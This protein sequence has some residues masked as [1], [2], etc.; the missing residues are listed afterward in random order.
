ML[1]E[2]SQFARQHW[3]IG[4]ILISLLWFFAGKQSLSNGRPD[5]AK[6]WQTIAV[7]IILIMCGWAVAERQWLGLALGITIFCMEARCIRD[8]YTEIRKN[9]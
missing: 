8:A 9:R 3:V 5:A 6:F 1:S 2:W 7:I 4:G